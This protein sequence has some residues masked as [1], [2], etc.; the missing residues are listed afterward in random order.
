M[1]KEARSHISRDAQLPRLQD[2][3]AHAPG[4]GLL[5]LD[6]VMQLLLGAV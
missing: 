5:L 6:E 4:L 1:V 3:D 2:D